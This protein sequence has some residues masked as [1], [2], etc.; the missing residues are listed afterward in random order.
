MYQRADGYWCGTVSGI[1]GNGR[2]RRVVVYGKTKREA[3]EKLDD[4]KR[5]P[6]GRADDTRRLTVGSWLAQWLDMA[7]GSQATTTTTR[8]EQL[9]RIRLRPL[10]GGVK[11]SKVTVFHV[12]RLLSDMERNGVSVRGREMAYMV[13]SRALKSAVKAKLIPW[14]PAADIEGKPRPPRPE[15]KVYTE[16]ESAKLLA[17][18]EGHRLYALL[19]AAMDSGARQGELFALTWADV[20][21]QASAITIRRTLEDTDAGPRL[22]ERT[23]T[24]KSRRVDLSDFAMV[25]LQEHRR[26]ALAAGHYG[27]DAP[28]F[29][30]TTGQW[31]RKSNF[32]RKTYRVWQRAAGVPRRRWHDL[33]HG[34]AT[35]LLG[36]NIP[37]KIVSERLGHSKVGIT[38]DTYSHVTPTMQ[39]GVAET[40]D[41][42]FREKT[43]T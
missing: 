20:D 39:R 13:L 1:D 14:N 37:A 36:R 12:Q 40:M 16:D 32:I 41:K 31:L 28:V 2:R 8:Y 22:K 3:L 9:I 43:G 29:C 42:Y 15:V 5:S 11:L 7:K 26:A 10:I 30:D 25:A 19:V 23:K 24:G 18:A 17:A 34:L 35:V 33:R 38:L 6:D 21:F 27:A 4:A